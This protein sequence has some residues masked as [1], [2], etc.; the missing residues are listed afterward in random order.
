MLALQG[1][2]AEAQQAIE[3]KED[4]L[5]IAALNGPDSV[6]ISG[7]EE[8]IAQ[9]EAEWQKQDKK[10]KRLATS[11]AFHS[12]L[13]EPMLEPFAEVAQSL[14]YQEPKIPIVSTL[15]GEAM[16]AQEA[17][18]PAYWVSQVRE[19]VRFSAAIANPR[20]PRPTHR[21]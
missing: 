9:V 1:S 12:A 8:A 7:T 10:L 18:D 21:P 5:S 2:E 16:S 17:T 15:S 4:E 6:V 3:G 13:M 20:C 11:H 14:T 19:P